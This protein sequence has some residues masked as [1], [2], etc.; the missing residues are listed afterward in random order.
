MKNNGDSHEEHE[1]IIKDAKDSFHKL[2]K[3]TDA[4]AMKWGITFQAFMLLDYLYEHNDHVE[5]AEAA[6]ELTIHR[7]TMTALLDGLEKKGV[8]TRSPHPQDRRRKLIRL[9]KV[10]YKKIQLI[11]AESQGLEK[12]ALSLMGES[13]MRHLITLMNKNNKSFEYAIKT[14]KGPFTQF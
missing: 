2:S 10:G 11:K 13:E 9:T 12:I 1:H 7:P 5:A 8:L 3:W 6:D 14:Y 4:Y